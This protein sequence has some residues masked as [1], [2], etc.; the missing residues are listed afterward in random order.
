MSDV[1]SEPLSA[2][3]FL[4]LLRQ[5]LAARASDFQSFLLIY[6]RI[7]ESESDQNRARLEEISLKVLPLLRPQDRVAIMSQYQLGVMAQVGD[8]ASALAIRER[9]KSLLNDLEKA[10]SLFVAEPGQSLLDIE[11]QLD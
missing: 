7:P 11:S 5:S 10:T 6:I 3:L 1:V 2:D 9:V 4:Q 8:E